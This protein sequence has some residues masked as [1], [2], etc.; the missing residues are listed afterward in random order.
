MFL[1]KLT[2]HRQT[3]R[4]RKK[5]TR[6]R[7]QVRQKHG[8]GG[9][10]PQTWLQNRDKERQ[11]LFRFFS[12]WLLYNCTDWLGVKHHAT[13]F[14]SGGRGAG[15]E[16]EFASVHGNYSNE[17]WEGGGR[18]LSAFSVN[19]AKE[20]RSVTKT[21]E[22]ISHQSQNKRRQ[23]F[24]LPSRYNEW[25]VKE[26]CCSLHTHTHTHTHTHI[27]L[28]VACGKE[29]VHRPTLDIK[30][31]AW[32]GNI[33]TWSKSINNE[34]LENSLSFDGVKLKIN[35]CHKVHTS[36]HF[37]KHLVFKISAKI[38]ISNGHQ[39]MQTFSHSSNKS[40]IYIHKS[41]N[42]HTQTHSRMHTHGH[43]HTRIYT[44]ACT[45]TCA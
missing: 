37:I 30:N 38:L 16:G 20:G 41:I 35:I 9:D 11:K 39:R 36:H 14:F 26:C 7:E 29:L 28:S 17:W 19:N 21:G 10:M 1:K 40:Y 5:Q 12:F 2:Q 22:G 45:N 32:N 44:S 23:S 43:K 15:L 13:F 25:T 4:E 18:G 6:K 33:S 8:V 27:M 34:K 31:H 3:D 42:I 24:T